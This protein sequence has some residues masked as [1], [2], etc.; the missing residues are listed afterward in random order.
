MADIRSFIASSTST[1]TDSTSNISS[2]EAESEDE[3]EVSSSEA[4][5]SSKPVLPKKCSKSHST[6]ST[7]KYLNIWEEDY[8]WQHCDA[9]CVGAFCKIVI[10]SGK[11]LYRTGGVWT[12][13]PFTNWKKA[14][15]RMR[16]HAKSDIHIQASVTTLATQ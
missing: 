4:P 8:P 5:S 9:D 2:S 11:S 3:L 15:D 13:K 6:S 1:S 10:A 12:T 14:C 16:D 7:R